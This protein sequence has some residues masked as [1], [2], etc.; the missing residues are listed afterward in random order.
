MV[1]PPPP[2]PA[3][4]LPPCSILFLNENIKRYRIPTTSQNQI[5]NIHLFYILE[6][7]LIKNY[8]M[9]LTASNF[10]QVCTK[11]QSANSSFI[12]YYIRQLLHPYLQI[13]FFTS[14]QNYIQYY[15][16]KIPFFRFTHPTHHLTLAGQSAISMTKVFG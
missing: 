6:V 4:P 3:P 14:F 2:P 16:K 7:L 10:L 8:R 11:D 1:G 5:K 13:L 15:L 12:S 9:I